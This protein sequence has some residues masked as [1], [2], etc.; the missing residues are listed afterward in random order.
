MRC[1]RR[2][3]ARGGKRSGGGRDRWVG[4][5][6]RIREDGGWVGWGGSYGSTIPQ[7]VPWVFNILILNPPVSFLKHSHREVFL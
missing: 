4:L 2:V 3:C 6:G 1:M 7:D 5:I